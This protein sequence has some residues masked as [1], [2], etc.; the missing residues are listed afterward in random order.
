MLVRMAAEEFVTVDEK[1]EITIP[2]K[3]I[4]ELGLK[5]H[6]LLQVWEQHGTIFLRKLNLPEIR[7][8]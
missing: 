2:K 3:F 8:E 4:K 1:G 7:K 5:P 6:S